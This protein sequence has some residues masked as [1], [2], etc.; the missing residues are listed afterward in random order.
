MKLNLP[1]S[2][3]ELLSVVLSVTVSFPARLHDGPVLGEFVSVGDNIDGPKL[4]PGPA[5][6]TSFD[7]YFLSTIQYMVPQTYF[8]PGGISMS[9]PQVQRSTSPLSSSMLDRTVI[10]LEARTILQ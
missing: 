6:K 2:T 5:N 9:Y 8:S 4:S 10:K 3:F 1:I 7:W